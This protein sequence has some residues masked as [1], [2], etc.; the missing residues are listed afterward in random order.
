MRQDGVETSVGLDIYR[1]PDANAVQTARLVREYVEGINRRGD[2]GLKISVDQSREVESAIGEVVDNAAIGMLLARGR[3]A[4]FPA[5][6]VVNRHHRSRHPHLDR[7]HLRHHGISRASFAQHHD[8]GRPGPRRR[9][10]GR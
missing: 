1:E 5:Q 6:R 2:F 4:L 9:H 7:R 10:A 8:L 3:A